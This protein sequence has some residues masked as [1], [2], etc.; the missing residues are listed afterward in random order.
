MVDEHVGHGPH[1]FSALEDGRAAHA[2]DDT[3]GPVQ[4]TLVG[5]L[6][7][8]VP[9]VGGVVEDF[10]DLHGILL[11]GVPFHVG[12]NGGGPFM[13]FLGLGHGDRPTGEGFGIGQMAEHTAFGVGIEGPQVS[14]GRKGPPEFS[15]PAVHPLDHPCDGG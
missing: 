2:L 12:Q 1:H 13:D 8:Q 14:L 4:Q 15:G 7:H 3:A 6:Q 11:H 9:G 10:Q 5:D